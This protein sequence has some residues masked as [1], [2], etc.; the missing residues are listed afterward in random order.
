DTACQIAADDPAHQGMALNNRGLALQE[1]KR[2][3]EAE[4]C[5]QQ[6]IAILDRLDIDA[7]PN[8]ARL[9][10]LRQTLEQNLR[11]LQ[12]ERGQELE[13]VPVYFPKNVADRGPLAEY[14]GLFKLETGTESQRL[15]HEGLSLMQRGLHKAALERLLQAR[16]AA[17]DLGTEMRGIIEC[18]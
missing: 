8:S 9:L 6:G 16:G 4:D 18:N 5:Y 3:R 7:E 10:E 2:L 17:D 15:M 1:L 14:R 11:S 13:D 12:S